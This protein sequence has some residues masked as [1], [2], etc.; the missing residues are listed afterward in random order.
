MVRSG[1][2]CCA[3]FGPDGELKHEYAKQ[4]LF[5]FSGEQKHYTAGEGCDVTEICGVKVATLVCY[6]LRFPEL[7]RQAVSRGAE[8]FVVPASWPTSRQLHWRTLLRA[9]AIENQACVVGISR[10]GKDPHTE[11]SGGSCVFDEKGELLLDA[12]AKEC[13]FSCDLNPEEIRKWR[14]KFPALADSGLISL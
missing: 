8:L 4:R 11:H 10:I 2:N 12:E 13:V 7:F 9:R 1:R 5:T 3:I 14:K 6:D